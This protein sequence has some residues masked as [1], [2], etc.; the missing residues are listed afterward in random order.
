MIRN[1]NYVD[2]PLSVGFG[3]DSLVNGTWNAPAPTTGN[4]A[5]VGTGITP[6]SDYNGT[7]P[8]P[9]GAFYYGTFPSENLN[10]TVNT[11]MVA[12]RSL[13]HFSQAWFS[14]FPEWRTTSKNVNF[15]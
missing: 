1:V 4:F 9:N 11:T 14:S 7:I 13:W 8:E 12:A 15:V 10:H 2:Q 5:F 6:L 3:Y